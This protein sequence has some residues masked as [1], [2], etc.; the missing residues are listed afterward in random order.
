MFGREKCRVSNCLPRKIRVYDV[1]LRDGF[2]HEERFIPT[3]AKLWVANALI[4]AGVRHLEVG[5]FSHVKYVPQFKD[6]LDV[7]KGLPQR[8]DVEYTA[9]ALNLKAC[10]R[11]AHA[12]AS[13]IKIDRVMCGQL[14]TSEAYARKNMNRTH[15]ELFAEA[16][17]QVKLL[18]SAGIKRIVAN[19][20]TIFGCPVQGEVP[21]ERAYE[22]TARCLNDI[23]FDEVSH[24]DTDG[25]A[26]PAKVYDYF[27]KTLEQFPDKS[28]HSFHV[29]D[30]R[31]M[32]LASYYAAMQAGIENFD[33]SLGGIGGQLA[34]VVDLVP[35]KGSGAYYFENC[36]TGLVETADFVSMVNA[37]GVETG[38]Q[39]APLHNAV[40]MVE[41][42]VGHP[43]DSFT[44]AVDR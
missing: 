2:Q 43:V 15:E 38:I 36:R 6:I 1:T 29:H 9:L 28:A 19:V 13:G 42:M 25:I 26:T 32:G 44:T 40:R 34:N 7:L 31:G 17:K 35:V 27:C 5:S 3:E 39:V 20:G 8:D 22:F 16:E 30:V 24:S 14:A 23:G 41:K 4:N 10:E 12:V 11:V 37:M 33:V 18:R 21:I